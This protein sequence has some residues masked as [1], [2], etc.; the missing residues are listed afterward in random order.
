MQTQ[1]CERLV[2]ATFAF[3]EIELVVRVSILGVGSLIAAR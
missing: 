1:H 3:L 2:E